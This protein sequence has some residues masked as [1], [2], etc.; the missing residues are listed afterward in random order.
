MFGSSLGLVGPPVGVRRGEVGPVPAAAARLNRAKLGEV[1]PQLDRSWTANGP[2]TKVVHTMQL[3][4][5][6]TS[7]ATPAGKVKSRRGVD[8]GGAHNRTQS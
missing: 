5:N 2:P 1:G 3:G 8:C 4:L 6:L 7:G